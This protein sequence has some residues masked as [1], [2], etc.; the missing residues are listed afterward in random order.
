MK[1]LPKQ[2]GVARV[3]RQVAKRRCLYRGG[4]GL[5]ALWPAPTIP[6][7]AAIW[8]WFSPRR[9]MHPQIAV[10]R[11]AVKNWSQ[12]ARQ[13]KDYVTRADNRPGRIAEIECRPADYSLDRPAQQPVRAG[14]AI[15]N[16]LLQP[17][18]FDAMSDAAA[19]T[20]LQ[21][22]SDWYRHYAPAERRGENIRIYAA[23]RQ[24]LSQRR[25]RQPWGGS[26]RQRITASPKTPKRRLKTF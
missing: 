7:S 21:T 1:D 18:T 20:L 2:T 17:A 6:N 23:I 25:C 14:E 19:R 4:R 5:A 3:D 16:Q 10:L 15:R 13:N 22:Q 26:K 11:E 9:R 12:T 8:R 24:T